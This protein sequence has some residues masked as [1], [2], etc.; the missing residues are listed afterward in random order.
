MKTLEEYIR[1]ESKDGEIR[2]GM[3]LGIRIALLALKELAIENPA[4]HHRS[5]VVVVETDRCL[6]DAIEIITGCRLGNR[7]LKFQ[8]M[9]KM[10]ATFV[11]L[12]TGRAMRVAANE[13]ANERARRMY[14][15]LDK[16]EALKSAYS[17][18]PDDDLLTR[19][20]V[21]VALAPED[22]PGYWAPRIICEECR[23]GIAFGREVAEGQRTLCRSCA[24]QGYCVPA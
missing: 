2:S 10:A 11:D 14:P 8:D 17:I 15:A 6:P 18:L 3:I 21:R 12:R 5:L 23:E 20:P 16:E 4:D 24:G 19:V 13:S 9:G 7:T 1:Q 22:V